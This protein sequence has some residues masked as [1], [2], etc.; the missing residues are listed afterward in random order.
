[1]LMVAAAKG[2]PINADKTPISI[3]PSNSSTWV[4]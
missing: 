1:M 2:A 3:P 4:M